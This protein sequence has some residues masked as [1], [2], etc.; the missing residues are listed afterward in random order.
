MPGDKNLGQSLGVTQKKEDLLEDVAMSSEQFKELVEYDNPIAVNSGQYGSNRVYKHPTKVGTFLVA[1]FITDGSDKTRG[2]EKYIES[3]KKD[4]LDM[5]ESLQNIHRKVWD[6]AEKYNTKIVSSKLEDGRFV[7]EACLVDGGKVLR[8]EVSD[9][10]TPDEW[11]VHGKIVK[12]KNHQHEGLIQWM[13]DPDYPSPSRI[14]DE[15][16][17]IC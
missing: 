7:H 15:D 11:F 16:G 6:D 12:L 1:Q 13:D 4:W 3:A 14:L 9:S 8:T 17:L 10:A 2:V 5:I